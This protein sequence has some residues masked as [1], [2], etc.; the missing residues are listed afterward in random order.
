MNTLQ[1]QPYADIHR[2]AVL[3][4]AVRA[5]RPVFARTQL[6]VPSFVY[7]AFYPHG[8]EDRQRRDLAALLD[9]EGTKLWLAMRGAIVVGFVGLRL[10]P[11]DRM[12][13]IHIIAVDPEQQ[14]QGVGRRLLAF[15]EQRLHEEGMAMVM[16]ETVGD[17]GHEP[18]RRTYERSGYERWPVARY[19]K[20]L[21]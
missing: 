7:N 10:H 18:A 19:F 1:I 5:W 12:G 16:V 4:I 17:S 3:A 15:A 13:E 14:R 20:R 2:Q 11:D 8:W 21:R 9:A 6:E